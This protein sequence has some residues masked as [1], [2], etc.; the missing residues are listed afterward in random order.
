MNGFEAFL[1]G[2]VQG[3][4]EFFPVSSSGHLVIL[5]SLMEVKETGILFEVSV[6]AATLIAVLIFYRRRVVELCRGLFGWEAEAI[7]YILLLVLA[8]LP[9]VLLV[10]V[11]GD[12]IEQQFKEPAVSGFCLLITG[13]LLWT[14][15]RTLPRAHR[16]AL[17]WQDALLVGCV[18]AVA[19]LPGISRSGSTVAIA[20]AL[21]VEP[22]MAAEF[23]FLMSA[24]AII[25]AIVLH[26]SELS[27]ASTASLHAMVIGGA[28]AVVS[29]LLALG[30][31]IRFLRSQHFHR[32]AYYV[33]GVGSLFLVWLYL[34]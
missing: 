18:Q 3:L 33:W 7:R 21:G 1:L 17:R 27:T 23:S 4:T 20:L 16:T 8:T 22:L 34:R 13:F 9:A 29:G 19:I 25:G 31:F 28:A 11:A 10:L 26:L 24:V 30:L 6:H 2:I 15:R 12:E 5:E 14:T 32:F